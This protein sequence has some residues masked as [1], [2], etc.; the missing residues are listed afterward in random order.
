MTRKRYTCLESQ[1]TDECLCINQKMT[2]SVANETIIKNLEN[3]LE[4]LIQQSSDLEDCK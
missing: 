1:E 2:E 4:R 3:Q